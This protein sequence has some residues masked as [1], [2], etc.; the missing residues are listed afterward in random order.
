MWVIVGAVVA[1]V[2]A[3]LAWRR[4]PRNSGAPGV[5]GAVSP[6]HGGHAGAHAHS[7]LHQGGI[8]GGF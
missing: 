6:D 2:G 7:N 1:A 3:G 4:R 5:R 8:S